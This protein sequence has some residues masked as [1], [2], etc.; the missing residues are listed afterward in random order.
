MSLWNS[1][2]GKVQVQLTSADPARMLTCINDRGIPVF[3]VETVSALTV[4]FSIRQRDCSTLAMLV[5]KRGDSL[6]ICRQE[7]LVWMV[8]PLLRRPVLLGGI[9]L[10]IAMMLYFPTRILFVQ[11]DGNVALPEK[12]ILAAAEECGIRFGASRAEVRSERLKNA[13]MA[14][15]PALQWAGINT[16]GCRAVISVRERTEVAQQK[17]KTG[18]GSLVS[19]RDA[20]VESVTVTRGNA[21]CTPGQAVKSGQM[22]ISGY[23]DCGICIRATGAEGEIYGQT[24]HRISAVMPSFCVKRT[25]NVDSK[26]KISIVIGKKRIN[27]WKDSG[28]WD[29]TCGRMYEEYYITLPGNYRLPMKLVMEKYYR[30]DLTQE[31]IEDSFAANL[32]PQFAERCLLD[33]MVAGQILSRNFQVRREGEIFRLEGSCLCREMIGRMQWEQIGE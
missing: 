29:T 19:V 32:L 11:V 26:K 30:Y 12:Q 3:S 17:A 4:R 33:Q 31:E 5:E 10:L 9:C 13:L 21:M 16:Y 20:L 25:R 7:G 6:K 27:L 15:L 24:T 28:I 18:I 1:I 14:R 2:R 8:K 22:L 23:V